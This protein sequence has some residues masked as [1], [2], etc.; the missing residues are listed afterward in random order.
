[1]AGSIE[2]YRFRGAQAEGEADSLGGALD[3]LGD[4]WGSRHSLVNHA[5][6][7]LT[8]RITIGSTEAVIEL[9]DPDL[10][11]EIEGG[12]YAPL[13]DK[14]GRD[15]GLNSRDAKVLLDEASNV[16]ATVDR[17]RSRTQPYGWQ[18]QPSMEP[19]AVLPAAS[20]SWI[21]DVAKQVDRE[22]QRQKG[23]V[24]S[25]RGKALLRIVMDVGEQ[26]GLSNAQISKRTGVPRSTIRDARQR[27]SREKRV[28]TQ[29]RTR[30]PGQRYTPDQ[31]KLVLERLKEA[32]GNAAAT[33]RQLGIAPRT[34]R[35]I[36]ARAARAAPKARV[37]TRYTQTDR[38]K[39]SKLI[40]SG[41]TPTAAG[42]KLG[43]AGR[44]ARSWAQK[45]RK[46]KK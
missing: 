42:R 5:W 34:V 2:S 1:M 35:D 14:L 38:D 24:R 28:V 43:V 16:T 31:Q 46:D 21:R 6:G 22:A 40:D 39:L 45:A 7:V 29:F 23:Q 15:M 25:Q 18:A 8:L 36:R 44:T 13:I 30:R 37:I 10:L 33:A 27:L 4:F 11:D 9:T 17:I 32:K 26:K 20:E 12:N 41:L 19:S 3:D